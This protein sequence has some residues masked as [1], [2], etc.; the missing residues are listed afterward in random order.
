MTPLAEWLHMGGYGWYVWTSYAAG[1]LI[2]VLNIYLPLRHHRLLR[3]RQ[4]P[5]RARRTDNEP[6]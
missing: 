4:A 6:A 5:G 1:L 3:T 2:I